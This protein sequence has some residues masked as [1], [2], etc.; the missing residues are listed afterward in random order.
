MAIDKRDAH[1]K[2]FMAFGSLCRAFAKE[3]VT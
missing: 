2:I 1:G 3:S